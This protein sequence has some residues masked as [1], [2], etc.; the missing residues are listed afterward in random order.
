MDYKVYR[1]TPI[2]IQL[3]KS[4]KSKVIL[5]NDFNK[6]NVVFFEQ[7]KIMMFLCVFLIIFFI[8][9]KTVTSC[10][11]VYLRIYTYIIST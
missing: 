7:S 5:I 1:Y 9:F 11:E 10:Y 6:K 3:D 4:K 8:F 2:N